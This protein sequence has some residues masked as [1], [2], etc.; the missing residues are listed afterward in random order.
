MNGRDGGCCIARY[1]GNVNS[2][3]GQISYGMSKVDKIMLKFRPI[4]P[5]PIASGS[6]SSSSTVDHNVRNRRRKRK[7]VRVNGNHKSKK[8]TETASKKRNLSSTSSSVSGGGDAVLTTLSL[9]P[10]TPDRKENSLETSSRDLLNYNKSQPILLRF[11]SQQQKVS[12]GHVQG[13][14]SNVNQSEI[15]SFLTMECVTDTW[16]NVENRLGFV[17]NHA[18]MEMDTCPWFITDSMDTVVWTNTAYREMTT[19][20]GG[21]GGVVGSVV[22]KYNRVTMPVPQLGFTCKMKVTWGSEGGTCASSVMAPCDVWRLMTG[23]YA[24]RL[25]VK[26]ALCLGR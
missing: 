7:Y 10:D 24:W 15:V 19:A 3:G 6:G 25:D 18:Q 22:A 16:I 11:D 12:Y 8:E 23:G 13:T 9:M 21:G 4:A 14:E 20:G 26:A 1:S 2:G 5:K 17:I